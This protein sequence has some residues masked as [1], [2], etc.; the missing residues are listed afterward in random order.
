LRKCSAG[1]R[2]EDREVERD[3]I[4]VLHAAQAGAACA[5]RVGP[6]SADT[7]F[8]RRNRQE[9]CSKVLPRYQRLI[10][11]AETLIIS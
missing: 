6:A 1:G 7:G 4:G 3:D 11:K 5:V 8:I 10:K 9:W 2:V